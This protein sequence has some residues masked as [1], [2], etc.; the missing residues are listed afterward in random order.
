MAAQGA[1]G[2]VRRRQAVSAGEIVNQIEN[3]GTQRDQFGKQRLLGGTRRRR[4]GALADFQEHF[5]H[6]LAHRESN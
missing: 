3:D 2:R 4:L 6:P 5:A 1:R